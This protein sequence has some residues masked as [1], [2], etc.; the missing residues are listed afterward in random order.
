MSNHTSKLRSGNYTVKYNIFDESGYSLLSREEEVK[1]NKKEKASV[2]FS[3]VYIDNVRKWTAETPNL[4]TL[5]I[6]LIN[7]EG[8]TVEAVSSNIGFRKIE[9]IDEVFHING[10]GYY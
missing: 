3:G 10:V 6:S 8:E 1:I 5:I 9:I 7:N 2:H 4:Y